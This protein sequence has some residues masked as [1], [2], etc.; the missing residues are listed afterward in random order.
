MLL[1][2][3]ADGNATVLADI[4]EAASPGSEINS[5]HWELLSKT[6]VRISC[7]VGEEDSKYVELSSEITST[8]LNPVMPPTVVPSSGHAVHF[9]SPIAVLKHILGHF[10]LA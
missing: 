7:I 6:P 5:S 3:R 9:E 8:A 10:R 2:K 1:S 4:L